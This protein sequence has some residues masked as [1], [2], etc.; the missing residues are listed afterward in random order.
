MSWLQLSLLTTPEN[1]HRVCELL[2]EAGADTVTMR[3]GN[4][5]AIYEPP[6]DATALW[7][8]T[9]VSGLFDKT[10]DMDKV[11]ELLQTSL[12]L[13]ELPDYQIEQLNDE[14][15]KNKWDRRPE[16]EQFPDTIIAG[17]FN[18]KQAHLLEFRAAEKADVNMKQL[19]ST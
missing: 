5:E 12:Q 7:T 17:M 3:S 15:W 13:P 16:L 18:F 1:V 4:D 19:F 9:R 14:D 2:T 8:Y 10:I 6:P 11:L